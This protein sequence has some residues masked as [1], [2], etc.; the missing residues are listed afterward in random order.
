MRMYRVV[1]KTP[2]TEQQILEPGIHAALYNIPEVR[3]CVAFI[4]QQPHVEMI[5]IRISAR[6]YSIVVIDA[7][8]LQPGH[9]QLSDFD[10]KH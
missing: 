6:Y 3:D 8:E 1:T 10:D 9:F 5:G 2:D 4:E 7:D